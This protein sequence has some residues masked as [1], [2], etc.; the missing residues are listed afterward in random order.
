[1]R[2]L[3]NT[4][5]LLLH[6]KTGVG[7]YVLNIY[8]ELTDAGIEVIPTLN[9]KSHTLINSLSRVSSGLRSLY[10]KRYLPVAIKIGD[11]IT[12]R[13]LR[14]KKGNLSYDIYHETSIDPMPGVNAV[15][16][17]NLYD[18]AVMNYGQCFKEDFARYVRENVTKNIHASRR[19]MVNTEFIKNEAISCLKAPEDKIDVIPLAP[20]GRYY[21]INDRRPEPK[22]L[23]R[24]TKKNYVLYV[25]TVEPRKNLKVLI[26]AFSLVKEKYDLSLIIAGGRGWLYDDII[27]Y[28]E[29]L[30]IKGDVIFTGYVDEGTLLYLYNYASVFVYPSLYEGFGLPPLEAMSCGV[31]VITSD[32]PALREVV[33]DAG[34]AFKPADYEELANLI[35]RVLTSGSLQTEMGEKGLLKAKGYSWKKVAESTIETYKRAMET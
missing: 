26:R 17:C 5:P 25:G 12:D 14:G 22:Q 31:P 6:D 20:S 8:R 30:G 35:E 34:L 24:F 16:V 4:K 19:I 18:L 13:L 2:V 1:M 3:L 32:I 15:S 9:D 21:R 11:A 7:Y 23:R 10:G 29:D 33:G 28:P 27:S